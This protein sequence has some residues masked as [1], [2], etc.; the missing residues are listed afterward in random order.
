MEEVCRDK[1][2]TGKTLYE[3]IEGLIEFVFNRSLIDALHRRVCKVAL[4]AFL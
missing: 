3:K 2:I 4:L 1:K